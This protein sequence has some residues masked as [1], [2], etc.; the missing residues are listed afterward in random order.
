M[1]EIEIVKGKAEHTNGVCIGSKWNV[2]M[3]SGC[4]CRGMSEKNGECT[5]CYAHYINFGKDGG[6]NFV[7]TFNLEK[8][9][10]FI[11]KN[12]V[13]TIRFGKFTDP[14]AEWTMNILRDFIDICSDEGVRPIIV[15]KLLKY[16]KSLGEKII[17]AR[18][19]I[20][21]SLG[22]DECEPGACTVNTNLQRIEE[23]AKYRADGVNAIVR[24]VLDTRKESDEESLYHKAKEAGI[25]VL[26]TPIRCKT[27]NELEKWT[28]LSLDDAKKSYSFSRGFFRV[29]KIHESFKNDKTCGE[30]SDGTLL[31]GRCYLDEQ[32][33]ANLK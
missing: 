3:T 23:C 11:C 5:Y 12:K 22:S 10:R 20:H 33:T 6:P 16:N 26:L 4:A 14:G 2:D 8:I 29:N 25:P 9:R 1:T 13:E 30:T 31:C 17:S 24:V 7:K 19:T 28:G 21:Y 18:G 15:T 27:K 32:R